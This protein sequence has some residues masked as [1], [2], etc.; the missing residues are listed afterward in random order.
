MGTALAL[1]GILLTLAACSTP[2]GSGHAKR[3]EAAT[4]RQKSPDRQ[5]T[6]VPQTETDIWQR[7]R[8]GFAIEPPNDP[9]IETE[10]CWYIDHPLFLEN[11]WGRGSRYLFHI[12]NEVERRGLPTELA[13]LPVVESAFQTNAVS[14]SNAVG[15][16]QFLPETGK[17]YGL[18]KTAWVD[19]RRDVIDSTRAAL[20]YLSA[21]GRQFNGDWALALAAYN[22][23]PGYVSRMCETNRGNGR[24]IGFMDLPLRDET[25]CYVPKLM[26]L[27]KLVE[28][29]ERYGITLPDIPN[30]P[31]FTTVDVEGPIRLDLLTA[32]QTLGSDDIRALNAGFHRGS[33][34]PGGPH[35]LLVPVGLAEQARSQLA[36][37]PREAVP[38]LPVSTDLPQRRVQWKRHQVQAGETLTGV[39]S[40][41]RVSI[42]A[43]REAN[44]LHTGTLKNG[45]DLLIPLPYAAD[46]RPGPRRGCDGERVLHRVAA[47]DSLWGIARRYQVDVKQISA[48][49]PGLNGNALAVGK[50]LYVFRPAEATAV[51]DASRRETYTVRSGDTAWRIAQNFGVSL[52][53]LQRWNG[54][55]RTQALKPG[56]QLTVI[57]GGG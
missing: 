28:H 19:Q 4:T 39:A 20:D 33:T 26:A 57:R 34:P 44:G 50:T 55:L 42:A 21:L 5:A 3:P 36:S 2:G 45:Q 13:L 43:L 48:C 17:D 46:S 25:R 15:L 1:A 53:Q 24:G 16:W 40:R 32:V 11:A 29:P 52:E 35:R 10:L 31:Y 22:G 27:R 41:Y 7:L 38:L 54:G 56:D 47:G 37:M 6:L 49:N 14:P 8:A 9:Q 12:L 18:Q 23:G 51:A 30:T